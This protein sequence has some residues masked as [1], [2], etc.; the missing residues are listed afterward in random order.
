MGGVKARWREV[1]GGGGS[2]RS[3]GSL[4][5]GYRALPSTPFVACL[6]FCLPPIQTVNTHISVGSKC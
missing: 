4:D 6:T 3:G 2:M 5:V 1:G